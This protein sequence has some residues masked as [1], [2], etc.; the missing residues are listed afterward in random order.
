MRAGLVGCALLALAPPLAMG[1]TPPNGTIRENSPEVN[2]TGGPLGTSPQGTANNTCPQ[3]PTTDIFNLTVDLPADF[4]ARRPNDQLRFT[5]AGVPGADVILTL[6]SSTNAVLKSADNNGPTVGETIFLD[7][8]AGTNTYKVAVCV[9]AGAAPQYAV[10]ITLEEVEVDPPP[11]LPPDAP[12][13]VT[14]V[15]TG[16]LGNDAGEP[17]IGYNI[18]SDR[19]MFI[20]GLQTLKVTPPEYSGL[21][22]AANAPFP[23][24]CDAVWDDVSTDLTGTTTLDPILFTN[25][26]LGKTGVNRTFVSQLTANNS[27]FAF[28]DDDGASWS[29]GQLGPSN[30]G[31]DH[32]TVSAGLYPATSP[33]FPVVPPGNPG[34]AVYY[35]SQSIVDAFCARSDN[36]GL[37]FNEGVPIGKATPLGCAA[38]DI[39]GLHGHVRIS[40][41]GV[42][43]MPMKSCAGNVATIIS[44][45]AGQTFAA[46]K[47]PGTS[48]TN[49]DPQ[50]AWSKKGGPDNKVRGYMCFVDGD[51]KPK[52]T[53]TRDN[54]QTW[55]LLSN[56]GSGHNIRHAVFAQS[57]AGDWDRAACAWLGTST[58]GNPDADDFAGV[59]YAYVSYTFDAGQ[60]WMTL[61]LAPQDAV[62]SWG[63]ICTGGI[64][65][66]G[67]NRNLLDFNEI[68]LDN[69]GRVWFGYADGCVSAAC[70]ANPT[71]TRQ[72]ATKATIE[73]QIGGKSLYAAF[74]AQ[75]STIPQPPCL[76]DAGASH[77]TPSTRDATGS[78]LRWKE[79]DDG[80]KPIVGYN[81]YRSTS[82]AG[83]YTLL[84]T[85][86][87]KITTFDDTTADAGVAAYFY[88]VTPLYVAGT[89]PVE[90]LTSN[91]LRLTLG[92]LP[93]TGPVVLHMH[94]NPTHNAGHPDEDLCTG[95]G[96]ADV[97]ACDGPFLS[98]S[99][100][101]GD[102]A[103]GH[104]DVP[105]PAL[106]GTNPRSIYD[107]QWIWKL[108]APA[109][110]QSPMKLEWW[111][112]CGACTSG[113][114]DAAWNIRV[115]VDGALTVE[116]TELIATPA[117][118]NV[119]SLLTLEIPLDAPLAPASE[120][121]V[122]IDPAFIDTQQNTHI[123]YDSTTPCT[124]EADPTIR[125]DSRITFGQEVVVDENVCVMPGLTVLT[126]ESGDAT[127]NQAAHD[128]QR[129]SVAEPYTGDGGPFLVYFNLKMG[130]LSSLP[131]STT[132]NISFDDPADVMRGVRMR[133]DVN[134]AV[135]FESF[136]ART[137]G[138]NDRRDGTIEQA[139]TV[140]AA[141]AASAYDPAT[142][143]VSIVVPAAD[144]G[145]TSAGQQ[146]GDF[147]VRITQLVA[148]P[149]GSLLVYPDSGPNDL[150]RTGSFTTVSQAFC[151]P[152]AAPV[153]TLAADVTE[154]EPPLEVTFTITG[155]DADSDPLA[156]FSLDFGDGDELEDVSFD[157]STTETHT[158]DAAGNF[159][160]RLTVKTADGR[161]SN[162]AERVITVIPANVAPEA[163]AGDDLEVEEGTEVT[164][165]GSATDDNG[166]LL[167]YEWTQTLGP[168]VAMNGASTDT[169]SFTAPDVPFDTSLVFLLKV[170]DGRGG[171]DTDTI[172]VRVLDIPGPKELGDNSV[173]GVPPL[174][175]LALALLG[176]LGRGRRR[177]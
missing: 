130:G 17:S 50:L 54:G 39:G 75:I 107:P 81:V 23:L 84:G 157:G 14:L 9:F 139:G 86:G 79:P 4:D 57:I 80:G 44:T 30:G 1:A 134:G 68:T 127:G 149:A 11:P 167:T 168:A 37:T 140:K 59:W 165:L 92:E 91:L 51:G 27:A 32:Q 123:Y 113:I 175:L 70:I 29:P 33:T 87:P 109:V 10:K 136:T 85:V 48:S 55:G 78:Y 58:Q 162:V 66:M 15:A 46:R 164:L 132:W 18:N 8:A 38:G 155:T 138:A 35:C 150:V 172:V 45:D 144:I 65:C 63:G 158:Y 21:V 102:G 156:T 119:P 49:T 47:V 146:L 125:C 19:A 161:V 3:N 60:T 171:E 118:P 94:G 96:A 110:L 6:Y 120:L 116:K 170:T 82:V 67:D 137:T 71:T 122:H 133:T 143:M 61:E 99:A 31:V 36:G 177:S 147:V 90:A 103:P 108:A 166:D 124:A 112:S 34:Y 169:L 56:L 115:Y 98:T 159:P 142:G 20:A 163:S 126:D 95:E 53:V 145:V 69:K 42:L 74:D 62:Q 141:H 121:L 100:Q 28:T 174:S 117:Q 43:A 154:G 40:D 76:L 7:A 24:A 106:D 151:A 83:S 25:Q 88:K 176:L 13:F 41:E 111:A 173:G 129:L 16:G 12:R 89:D 93:P 152:N 153:A 22:D 72:R 101:L 148:T 2:Y 104:W 135:F 131:P 64:N 160:A 52:A 105:N 26:S 97:A 73:R 77:N 5:L 114:A 128:L